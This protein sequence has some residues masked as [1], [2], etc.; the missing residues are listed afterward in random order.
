MRASISL[1]V[2]VAATALMTSTAYSAECANLVAR[3]TND[4]IV[5]GRVNDPVGGGIYTPTNHLGACVFNGTTATLTEFTGCID[6]D[7]STD[8]VRIQGGSG[9]DVIAAAWADSG[10]PWPTCGGVQLTAFTG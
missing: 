2:L 4:I 9:D 1:A 10:E 8:W 3:S 5:V 7:P 6:T